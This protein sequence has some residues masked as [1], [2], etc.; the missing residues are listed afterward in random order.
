MGFKVDL[1]FIW[2]TAY[3]GADNNADNITNQ[4]TS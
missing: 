4:E 2:S 1:K 3:I